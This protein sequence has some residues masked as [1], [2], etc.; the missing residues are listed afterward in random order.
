MTLKRSKLHVLV[1]AALAAAS[2]AAAAA[3]TSE[4]EALRADLKESLTP[5]KLAV[6]VRAR[7]VIDAL[8][9]RALE[10]LADGLRDARRGARVAG[11]F[12][13]HHS[14]DAS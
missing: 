2:L 10:R 12:D 11:G 3:D 5:L 6:S 8:T 13:D 14:K 7:I 4:G 9:E 1:A